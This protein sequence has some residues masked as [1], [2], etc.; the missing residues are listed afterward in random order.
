M[1]ILI[2]E[3]AKTVA[4]RIIRLTREILDTEITDIQCAGSLD[5]AQDLI[6]KF[7][8]D[9]L[10]LDLNLHGKDGY[11]LLEDTASQSFHTIIISAYSDQAIRAFE[12]GVLDFVPKP[13]S[14]ERLA[15][16]FHR[17]KD[18]ATP[19]TAVTKFLVIRT[20]GKTER[21]DLGNILYVKA[22]GSYSEIYLNNGKCL[23]H[24]KTLHKLSQILP[25][26]FIRTHK[27]YLINLKYF[28][29]LEK[30]GD[31]KYI[32]ELGP[33]ISLPLSRNQL[34]KFKKLISN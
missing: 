27:S 1:R 18:D 30:I 29:Q 10:L 19:A 26:T 31:H 9:L 6:K 21:I 15:H 25:S 32:I 33:S 17:L 12:F 5:E 22:A 23:T 20:C 13:F 2:V 8:P 7:P 28:T 24:C 14:K 3:D 16:A 4:N 34:N 11:G